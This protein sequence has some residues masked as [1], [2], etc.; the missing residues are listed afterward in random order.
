[1]AFPKD[2]DELIKAGYVFSNF[3]RCKVCQEEI[4]WYTTPRGKNMPFDLMPEGNSL[5][6]THFTTC[7]EADLFRK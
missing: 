1:M 5:A 7:E 4:E 3:A 2:R 6:V